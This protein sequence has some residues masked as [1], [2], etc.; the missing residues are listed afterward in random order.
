MLKVYRG[1][2]KEVEDGRKRRRRGSPR[3]RRRRGGFGVSTG[4][5]VAVDGVPGER[6]SKAVNRETEL[7]GVGRLSVEGV[8]S[9]RN[10]C[11]KK[12]KVPICLALG[13]VG[14]SAAK[15]LYKGIFYKCLSCVMGMFKWLRK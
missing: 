6:D 2:V 11:G 1:E 13:G 8:F 4:L 10:C 5:G 12:G 9:N 3:V 14:V 15:K 7:A